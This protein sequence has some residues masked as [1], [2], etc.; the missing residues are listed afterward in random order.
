MHQRVH[1]LGNLMDRQPPDHDTL[2]PMNLSEGEGTLKR[3][4][5]IHERPRS[6]HGRA[7]IAAMEPG[8]PLPNK[9]IMLEL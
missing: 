8:M 3:S 2:E 9:V 1:S 4:N 5:T 7:S 6:I